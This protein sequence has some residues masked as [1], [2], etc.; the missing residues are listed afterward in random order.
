MK[1][2][3][4][5]GTISSRDAVTYDTHLEHMPHEVFRHVCSFLGFTDL[6]SLYRAVVLVKHIDIVHGSCFQNGRGGI[7][8]C[9]TIPLLG[10]APLH[11]DLENLCRGVRELCAEEST[12]IQRLVA[13]GASDDLGPLGYRVVE[14]DEAAYNNNCRRGDGSFDG[15]A[16]SL[17]VGMRTHSNL[18][19]SI[20]DPCYFTRMLRYIELCTCCHVRFGINAMWTYTSDPHHLCS[21]CQRALG[22][23][24]VMNKKDM[25]LDSPWFW[26]TPSHLKELCG[27]LSATRA[28][29]FARQ[30]GIRA[31]SNIV[32]D[33]NN[34]NDNNNNGNHRG[35]PR[36][37][38]YFYGDIV[39]YLYS[40]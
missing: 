37:D 4:V 11:T 7:L 24:T 27:V 21:V 32:S 10:G 22:L 1:R 15:N 23:T 40:K 13:F 29:D 38:F 20:K 36:S 5:E 31:Q 3:R 14:W 26:I 39:R 30:H 33:N 17:M 6:H 12:R 8:N 9:D 34:N 35:K 2:S 28:E 18:S 19:G 25:R 16:H